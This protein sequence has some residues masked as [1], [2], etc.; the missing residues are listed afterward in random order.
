MDW[1]RRSRICKCSLERQLRRRRECFALSRGP[2]LAI[3]LNLRDRNEALGLPLQAG[4]PL[5]LVSTLGFALALAFVVLIWRR[6]QKPSEPIR[7][8]GTGIA[9]ATGQLKILQVPFGTEVGEEEQEPRLE[10]SIRNPFPHAEAA[11]ESTTPSHSSNQDFT[12]EQ[13]APVERGVSV[14]LEESTDTKT[15]IVART[16]DAAG[17]GLERGGAALADVAGEMSAIEDRN[18]IEF[19]HGTKIVAPAPYERA[20][21]PET[22]AESSPAK[23]ATGEAVPGKIVPLDHPASERLV[24]ESEIE[25][26]TEIEIEEPEVEVPS[27]Y[28]PPKLA[29][30]KTKTKAPSDRAIGLR[31]DRPQAL[32]IRIRARSD[33]HG[34]CEFQLLA[35]RCDDCPIELELRQGRRT[36]RFSA[37]SDGWY[38]VSGLV[39]I[40]DVLQ[41]GAIL[42]GEGTTTWELRGRPLY[43]LAPLHGIFGFVS[44]TRLDLGRDQIVLCRQSHAAEVEAVL[45]EAGCGGIKVSGTER[46]APDGWAFYRSAKPSRA[47]PQA[48]GNDI[49]NLIRPVPDIEILLEGGLWLRNS[50]W[51]AGYPPEIR[52]GGEIP[53]GSIV[54]IDGETAEN[55]GDRIFRTAASKSTGTHVVWCGGKTTSY[56]ISEPEEHWERWEAVRSSGGTVCGA[57]VTRESNTEKPESL[58]SVPTSNPILIGA[59][60]G[61]I[62]RCDARPGAQWMGFVPFPV[63]WALPSDPLHCDRSARKAL[64]VNA[65]NPSRGTMRRFRDPITNSVLHWCYAILDC[66]RKGLAVSP[67]DGESRQL[68]SDYM[69]E[70]KRIRRMSR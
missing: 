57:L 68:W 14:E 22:E 17:E 36:V 70:A 31:A 66:R 19:S 30:S 65:I 43:V 54:T 63:S 39:N 5:L 55:A 56:S 53:V 52:V 6:R 29:T 20:V 44:T 1:Y 38:E 32:E 46:G 47:V 60:P 34:F 37:V 24:W 41:H 8:V 12:P 3:A 45:A 7:Q 18:Q 69:T 28:Q 16:T 21:V 23:I 10:G 64:L 49:L 58:L 2:R 42:S 11:I 26:V 9:P 50:T 27:R 4:N 61:E 35:Q 67:G 62:F 59:K 48:S 40:S 15:R 25:T 33:R 51:I 13:L